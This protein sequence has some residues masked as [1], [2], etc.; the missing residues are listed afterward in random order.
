MRFDAKRL[1]A[2]IDLMKSIAFAS[3]CRLLKN[4]HFTRTR[5]MPLHD[6]LLSILYRHGT[7]LSMELRRFAELIESKDQISKPGYLKQR[8]KLN[9]AAIKML[10]DHHSESLYRDEE[11]LNLN[12]YLLLAA[13]GSN[14]NIPTT[15]ETLDRYGTSSKKGAKR[16]SALGLS[17]LYDLLNKVVLDATI[18][19][20]KFSERE[21]AEAHIASVSRIIGD[22]NTIITLDRNY[23]G[24]NL[25]IKW[26]D[27]NQKFV[28][29]LKKTDYKREREAMR[30]DDENIE[31]VLDKVRLNPYRGTEM[32][33]RLN[34]K[35]SFRLRIVNIRRDNQD[36]VVLA[37][38]LDPM[39]FD[40]SDIAHIYSMRWGI[41]TA[42]DMLKNN[43]Q[44]ENFTGTKP[45][46]IEQD[47]FASIYLCNLVQDMIADAE[48]VNASL[49]KAPGKYPMSINKTYAVGVLKEDLIKAIIETD[50][51][52]RTEIFNNMVEEIKNHVLPVRPDRHYTRNKNMTHSKYPNTHK[53]SF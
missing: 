40:T 45:T 33:E 32:W 22:R 36:D 51:D 10:C 41:E 44:I 52:K 50:I 42:F 2:D 27:D 35:G 39:E 3:K 1:C 9:P 18:N 19:R 38:N 6:L 20:V 46:L 37:T 53:R 14:I 49:G 5:K 12:G 47:I 11:M 43:L 16:Q 21:Q 34:A 25:F 15:D 28:M 26:I 30:S 31:V 8:M 29:R 13:D 4:T 24:A 48:T 17:C 7:T 23:P